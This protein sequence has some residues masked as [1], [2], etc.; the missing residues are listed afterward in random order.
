[1]G[2]HT[3]QGTQSSSQSVAPDPS[4]TALNHFSIPDSS[5]IHLHSVFY[6]LVQGAGPVDLD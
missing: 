3:L 4:H 5:V 2:L 1:M 6:L